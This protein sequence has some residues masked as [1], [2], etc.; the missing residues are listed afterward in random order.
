MSEPVAMSV[1]SSTLNETI[2][3]GHSPMFGIVFGAALSVPLW[4]LIGWIGLRLS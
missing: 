4:V 2:R 1:I 3:T